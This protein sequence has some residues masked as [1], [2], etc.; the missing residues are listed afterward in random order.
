ML[1]LNNTVRFSKITLCICLVCST[2]IVVLA[3]ST[4]AAGYEL[5]IYSALI[6]WGAVIVLITLVVTYSASI[7]G[8]TTNHHLISKSA[9]VGIQIIQG[10]IISLPLLRGYYRYGRGDISTIIGHIHLL[11]RD[12]TIGPRD[13]YPGFNIITINIQFLTNI[14][15]NYVM[16]FLPFLF[17]MLTPLFVYCLARFLF[18]STRKALLASIIATPL[19]FSYRYVNVLY[20]HQALSLQVIPIL[21]L[22]ILLA[23]RGNRRIK[24]PLYI[25]TFSL[26]FLHPVSA[27][28]F[29]VALLISILAIY[30]SDAI[31]ENFLFRY[32]LSLNVVGR[33]TSILVLGTFTWYSYLG[34][35]EIN[36]ERVVGALIG[37]SDASPA[38]RNFSTLAQFSLSELLGLYVVRFGAVTILLL[39]ASIGFLMVNRSTG[40]RTAFLPLSAWFVAAGI[41]QLGIMIFQALPLFI[42]RL[43]GAMVTLS[44]IFA[45]ECFSGG[46]KRFHYAFA[47]GVILLLVISASIG[48]ISAHPSPYSDN[49]GFS[50]PKSQ[51]DSISWAVEYSPS[52]AALK[53]IETRPSRFAERIYGGDIIGKR[54]IFAR[55]GGGEVQYVLPP[56]FGYTNE[57]NEEIETGTFALFTPVEYNKVERQSGES[58]QYT[59]E[60]LQRFQSDPR[61]HHVYDNGETDWFAIF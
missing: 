39:V 12:G 17:S 56:H 7:W 37:I 36:I 48:M 50:L 16:L 9:I 11:I 46:I 31:G 30:I 60:D 52:G 14:E 32:N 15:L 1:N 26:P 38:S 27:T 51:I 53:S 8:V 5:N 43:V 44:Y 45:T 47:I 24:I 3:S 55:G 2:A 42:F 57:T 19:Y 10:T 41:L 6:P 33:L 20:D 13:Y 22:L 23:Y 59:T 21:I 35:F 4:P 25:S 61:V 58:A 34:F 54:N 49:A 18:G 28:V 40:T 29:F